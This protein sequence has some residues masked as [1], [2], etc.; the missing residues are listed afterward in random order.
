MVV[1]KLILGGKFFLALLLL[2]EPQ[3]LYQYGVMSPDPGGFHWVSM[4]GSFWIPYH[5]QIL[6]SFY[7]F[8]SMGADP[9]TSCLFQVRFRVMQILV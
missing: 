9:A 2:C 5:M 7:L 8:K 4:T 1:L 6:H 3:P